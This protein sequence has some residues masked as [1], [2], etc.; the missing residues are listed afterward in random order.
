MT[1][2]EII[3]NAKDCMGFCK[4]C[5]ICNGKVCKNIMPGPGAKGVGDGAIRNYD[6]W[7]D[8]RLNMD[9]ICSNEDVD[10]SFELFGK[11]FKYPIFAG[12]VGAVQLHYG[13]KY[14]DEEYNDILVQSCSEAGI[15]AFT[16]DG[17]NPNVMIAATSMIKKQNGIGIPTVKPWNMDVIKEKMKLIADSNAFAVAMDI[18]GAGLPFLKNLTP[19][20]GSKTAD[21]LRQIKEIAKRPFI[22]KGIMT[23]KG[24]QK[25]VESGADAIIVSNHGGRVLDQCASTA[26]VL[27]EIAD[28][29]KGK[30]KILVD[31]GIRSG[32][33]ILKALALGADGAVIARTFVIAVYGGGEEGVKSYAAQLGAELEDAMAMCGVH[34]LKEITRDIVRL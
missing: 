15:C 34:S 33:D 30:I 6:K 2:K 29:V 31:G 23:V 28:A 25:A 24:A 11:K 5:I 12:P 19:K 20:A 13:N 4:A 3:E 10:A 26:E 8:I 9:T 17:V 27:P 22:I 1:Y 16:G 21:E 18:D 32:A 7:G 14:T